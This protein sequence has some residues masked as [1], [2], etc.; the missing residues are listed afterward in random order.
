M[1]VFED[2]G[3]LMKA[4]RKKLG[5]SEEAFASASGVKLSRLQKWESGTNEPRFSIPELRRLRKLERGIF[6]ELISVFILL[7]PTFPPTAQAGSTDGSEAAGRKGKATVGASR[8]PAA[9]SYTSRNGG[10]Q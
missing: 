1:P 6:E 8:L 3:E 9:R 2:Q 4:A 7:A 5:L 10:G